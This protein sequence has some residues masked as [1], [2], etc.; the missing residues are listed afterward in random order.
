MTRRTSPI[1]S[2]SSAEVGSSN[3]ITLGLHRERAGDRHALLLAAGEPLGIFVQLVAEADL[4]QH[5]AAARGGLG[6]C[7]PQHLARRDGDVLERRQMREQVEALEDEADLLPLLGEL[8]V[9]EMDVLAVARLALADQ[10]AVDVDAAGA[11][12]LEIVD[13]AQQGGLARAAR[14]DDRDDLAAGHIEVDAGQ[15]LER[16]EALV[17]VDD[18]QQRIHVSARSEG[19]GRTCP[20]PPASRS[21]SVPT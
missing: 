8:A 5:R 10:L 21:A 3:S 1:S 13:A 20:P 9:A 2:G 16:E 12:L 6:T 17:Q 18:A 15:H 4:L 11:R 7:H 14:A 19:A